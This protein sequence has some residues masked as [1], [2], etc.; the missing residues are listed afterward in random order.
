MNPYKLL[1]AVAAVA[2]CTDAMAQYNPTI[3]V[4]GTYKPEVIIQERVNFFPDRMRFGAMTSALEY[5]RDGVVTDFTP[6][7]V[8]MPATGW[9]TDPDYAPRRGCVGLKMGS[10][11]DTRLH[12]CYQFVR[13][14]DTRAGVYL[15]YNS[16]SL[17]KP[18]VSPETAD[19][20]RRRQQGTIGLF[21]RHNVAGKG[22]LDADVRY[23]VAW[24][25]YYGYNPMP[26]VG[27]PVPGNYYDAPTQTVND[28]AVRV[29]WTSTLQ[30]PL[31][32][33]AGADIRYVG[34][35]RAYAPEREYV[36]KGAREV[37]ASPR[38]GIGWHFR[39][40]S[41]LGI[42]FLADFVTYTGQRGAWT[43]GS[44]ID[45]PESYGRVSLTPYYGYAGDR[46]ELR[47]GPRIDIMINAGSTFNIA[48]DFRLNWHTRGFAATVEA[49]GGTVLNTL[50]NGRDV[51]LYTSPLVLSGRPV[52]SPFDGKVKL[53]F[54]PFAG[55]RGELWF[56]Y[57]FANHQ[58]TGGLYP[59]MLNGSLPYADF[60]QGMAD[61][62]NSHGYSAGIRLAY[63]YG[64]Y[65]SLSAGATYQ[66]QK[67]KNSYWNGW[68][69]PKATVDASLGI[70][71]WKPLHLRLDYN[72]R[73]CRSTAYMTQLQADGPW[74]VRNVRLDNI[75]DLGFHAAYDILP[76]LSVSLDLE[77]LLN[78]HDELLPDLPMPGLTILGG[79]CYR[80]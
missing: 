39:G 51:S 29:M 4:E 41:S 59:A 61:G 34:M 7:G 24:F 17:W 44:A 31:R 28:A 79:V 9:Q 35:R 23:N 47:A 8:P 67:G 62:Y 36:V 19:T 26:R 46:F 52:Y 25:N 55:F 21:L 33:Y 75:S 27:D 16:T 74:S 32:Y 71:P 38:L 45:R 43:G 12:G 53:G 6:F 77:N 72:L 78:R 5:D 42:D 11:L 15:N 49:S 18:E 48:P 73:A 2:L 40:H 3:D 54:G 68:D 60:L 10:W 66:P 56:G 37:T 76:G 22:S 58:R 14:P 69:L 63:N 57:R 65:F 70:N 64:R 13:T 1:T 30:K 20:R 50:A 80:F